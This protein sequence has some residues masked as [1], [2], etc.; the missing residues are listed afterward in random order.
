VA[1]C[2]GHLRRVKR[3]NMYKIFV[4]GIS[5]KPITRRTQTMLKL[6]TGEII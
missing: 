5:S 6:I 1:V 4:S 3:G 2:A